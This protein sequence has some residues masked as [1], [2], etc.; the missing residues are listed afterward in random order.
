MYFVNMY[1]VVLMS[2]K[3]VLALGALVVVIGTSEIVNM[4]LKPL[5]TKVLLATLDAF[6]WITCLG[7]VFMVEQM[8]LELA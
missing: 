5:Q 3:G 6:M 7:H 4:L 2:F 8:F 1:S